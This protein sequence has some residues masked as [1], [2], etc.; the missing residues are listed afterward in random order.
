MLP[1][2]CEGTGQR[3]F[4]RQADEVAGR[5]LFIGILQR[6]VRKGFNLVSNV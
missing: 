2:A 6:F 3:F 4:V 1:C 5:Y